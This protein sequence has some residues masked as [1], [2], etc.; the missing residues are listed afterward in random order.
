MRR[1]KRERTGHLDVFIAPSPVS[2][3]RFGTVVPKHGHEIVERNRLRRRLRE[4][5]R[6]RVLPALREE[7]QTVDVLVLAHRRAYEADF[8]TLRDELTRG[9]SRWLERS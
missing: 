7:G 1:G 8:A 5:G 3:S 4:V 2:H 6:C 9:V